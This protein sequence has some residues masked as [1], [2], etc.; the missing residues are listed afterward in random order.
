MSAASIGL[1]R[2]RSAR[3]GRRLDTPAVILG[4]DLANIELQAVKLLVQCAQGHPRRNDVI[5]HRFA[6]ELHQR[7]D[8]RRQC[9]LACALRVQGVEKAGHREEADIKLLQQVPYP[10]I[11]HEFHELVLGHDNFG[12]VVHGCRRTGRRCVTL[13][14]FR[15]PAAL[16]Q[17]LDAPNQMPQFPHD[18]L[19]LILQCEL[20]LCVVVLQT[21]VGRFD[22]DGC[23]DIKET[24]DHDN[25]PTHEHEVEPSAIALTES[26]HNRFAVSGAIVAEHK[27]ERREHGHS[28]IPEKFLTIKEMSSALSPIETFFN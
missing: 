9:D 6:A 12:N 17:A 15:L 2:R 21:S 1:G 4:G 5:F 22:K 16:A 20:P 28:D 8:H 3:I 10:V 13:I 25:H 7:M 11:F 18:V 14:E 19:P 27:S 26:H 23:D 24:E